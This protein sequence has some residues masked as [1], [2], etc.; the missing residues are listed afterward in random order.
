MRLGS[1]FVNNTGGTITGFSFTYDGEEW[2]NPGNSATIVNNQYVVS[3]AV[4]GAGAGSLNSG[5]YSATIPSATFDT[6]WDGTGTATSAALDGNAAANRIA[7]L[8]ATFTELSIANGDEIWLR[9]WD[10]NSSLLDAGI[11]ID[12]F[13][14]TFEAAAI[15]E[16]SLAALIGLVS[17]SWSA[18]HAAEVNTTTDARFLLREPLASPLALPVPRVVALQGVP[19]LRRPSR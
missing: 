11:A 4:F 3:Y 12:N 10:S 8:G 5:L 1:R 6:P 13:S 16:P 15:P 17:F 7:G 2:R 18:A 9:W 14:I 19:R